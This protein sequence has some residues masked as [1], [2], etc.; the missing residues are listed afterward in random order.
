MRAVLTFLLLACVACDDGA[1]NSPV[2]PQPEA[3]EPSVPEPETPEPDVMLEP[4]ADAG[5]MLDMGDMAID[6]MPPLAECQL[7]GD[8]PDSAPQLGCLADFDALASQSVDSSIPGARS[9]KTIIDRVDGNRLYFINSNA[10]DIHWAFASATL[11]GQGLPVVPMLAGFNATE[12]S[13]PSRRFLLGSLTYYEG[14]GVFVYELAPYDTADADMI[15]QAYRAIAANTWIGDALRFH[16]SSDDIA[17]VAADLAEDVPVIST[18]ALFDGIDY[19]PLNVAESYGRLRFVSADALE[20]EGEEQT[21]LGFRDIVVLEAVPN[22]ISVVAGII[23]AAFQTP[24][25]HINVLSKNRGTPN[26]GLRGAF[27]DPA[28]RALDGQWVRLDVGGL[29]YTVEGV[30]Q[31]VADAW[32]EDN[33]PAEVGIPGADLSVQTLV[34]LDGALDPEL[35]IYDAISALTRAVGGKAAHFSVLRQIDDVPVPRGFAVPLHFYFEFMAEHGF[36]VQV[37]AMLA[38]PA[39]VGDPAVRDARLAEL[40]DQMEAAPISAALERALLVKIRGEFPG[41][42]MRFRSST[43]AED[44]DGFT[45]AGLYTSKSGDPDDPDKP[46]VDAVRKVWASVWFFRAFEERSYRSIDH[47]AVGMALLVHRSF[48]DEAA[49][50]VALTANPFDPSGLEPAFF[51]NV[52]RGETSVVQPPPGV[53]T[54]SLLYFFDRPGQPATFLSRSTLVGEGETVLTGTQLFELGEAL[55]RLRQFFTPIYGP[56]NDGFWAMDVEFKFDGQPPVLY[57]KQARPFQ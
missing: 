57:I 35:P 23:T 11:S 51:I 8:L 3:P 17:R 30:E 37:D 45:G 20:G 26:M 41:L 29:D 5:P 49:N 9:L 50:G 43:N 48:P 4:A 34:D 33:K 52:Q 55:A 56:R 18:D 19:Q 25:S 36:D 13:S 6:A 31:A 14:P 22:D 16:P 1:G 38:D 12:Y 32:W 24:L 46:I 2:D 15:A 7:E 21:Y 47:T 40:R 42:R 39:F 28:L 10:F 54:E 27:D 44:L 53:L